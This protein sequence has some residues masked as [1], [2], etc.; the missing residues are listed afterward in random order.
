MW[1]MAP[2]NVIGEIAQVVSVSFRLY[3]NILGGAII[4][5]IGSQLLRSFIAPPFMVMYFGLFVG[6]VQAF[7][8]TMLTLVYISLKVK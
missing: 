5:A 7:V 6:L 8:F 3:G 1:F 4:I 2:L